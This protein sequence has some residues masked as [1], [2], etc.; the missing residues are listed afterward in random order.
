ME[1]NNKEQLITSDLETKK[2]KRWKR[3][4]SSVF[5]GGTL[6]ISVGIAVGV[7]YTVKN[8]TINLSDEYIRMANN[9]IEEIKK[10]DLMKMAEKS[11]Y[12]QK[13]MNDFAEAQKL[14]NENTKYTIQAKKEFA[15]EYLLY[16]RALQGDAFYYETIDKVNNWPI[17]KNEGLATE[18]QELLTAAANLKES[19][20]KAVANNDED[21]LT[22][23]I[24]D[25]LVERMKKVFAIAEYKEKLNK[26]NESLDEQI[27]RCKELVFE[28]SNVVDKT[29]SQKLSDY[30]QDLVSKS[31]KD[32][33]ITKI[34]NL[35][36][37]LK[38]LYEEYN[39]ILTEKKSTSD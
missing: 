9:V 21:T 32:D 30:V 29:N 39:K 6:L 36:E 8:N 4:W 33:S 38:Q 31:T 37:K 19:I 25:F 14:K 20:A 22:F 13:T 7:T 18:K 11:S 5:F 3:I 15:E 34:E 24:A 10:E 35:L 2:H 12:Y 17:L 28:L 27:S 26:I 16:S 1:N 23:S